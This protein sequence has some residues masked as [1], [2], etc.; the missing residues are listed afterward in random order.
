M[1]RDNI[2]ALD[3]NPVGFVQRGHQCNHVKR[4]KH[5][6]GKEIPRSRE[7]KFRPDFL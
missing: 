3:G 6:V 7:I 4:I 1:F 2:H 5:A